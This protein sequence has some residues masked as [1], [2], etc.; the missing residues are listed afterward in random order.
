M[1]SILI[2]EDDALVRKTLTSQLAKGGFEVHRRR[3]RRD[4]ASG[5]TPRAMPDLI[6]LDIRL[7]DIDGLEVLRRIRE[8]NRRAI[9]LVM[10]AFDDMKTTVEAVKLGALRIPRQAPE[11]RRARPDH[12]KGPPGPG[13]GG[14]G[15][16][17]RRGEAEGVHDRQH[18][19]PLAPDA[20]RFQDD[21]L[22]GRYPDQHPHPG[23]ERDGQ[24]TRGQG[25]PLQQPLPGRAFHRHQLL[26]HLRHAPR[27][28]ALRPRQGRVH[29]RRLR[30][31]G[32]VRDRRQGDPLP[33][34]GRRRLAQPAI[35][36]PPGHRDQGLHEGRRRESPQD[37][38]ANHRGHQPEPPGPDRER[39]VP[40]GPLLPAQ[41][42][43]DHAV[44]AP[45]KARGHPGPHGL[46]PR[47]DQPRPPAGTSGRSRPRS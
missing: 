8:R 14:E 26:R 1:K 44:A 5:P 47:E 45:G 46:P 24:G 11:H 39:P 18:R 40:G 13:P 12:R 37:R 43:R 4:R 17:P 10:T 23:R 22:G 35:Q 25:H 36:A 30:D 20:G 15:Q 27:E 2:I 38:G 29:R 7:P 9:I 3:G 28:R 19:R 16:L 6:L 31:E 21:R 41:G 34:R 33:G 32:Q 42:R